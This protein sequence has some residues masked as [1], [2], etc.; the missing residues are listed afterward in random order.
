MPPLRVLK[1]SVTKDAWRLFSLRK[2]D[3]KFKDF[4]RRV[5]ERD[6]YICQFCGFQAIQ[7]QEI[8]NLDQDY[9][10]NKIA[11]LATACCFCAQCFFLEAVGKDDNSG[12]VLIYLPEIT[13]NELNGFCHVLFCAMAN[14][15]NYRNDAQNIYRNLKLRAQ[16]VEKQLGE[17]MSNPSLLGQMLNDTPAKQR[18][19]A[20]EEIL[21]PLRLLPSQSRFSK[22][23]ED[24]A[25]AALEELAKS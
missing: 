6:Q 10:N 24:W 23:I 11:N 14:A 20:G 4:S 16:L 8:V 7:H 18:K 22:Q 9:R 15:T 19:Q 17:N 25:R 3:T 2:S 5:F 12:G 1:L 21:R 13:Q